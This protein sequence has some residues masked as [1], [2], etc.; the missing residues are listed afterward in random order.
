MNE[1]IEKLAKFSKSTVSGNLLLKQDSVCIVS[2]VGDWEE[3]F[4]TLSKRPEKFKEMFIAG[5]Y[6]PRQ[7]LENISDACKKVR[8]AVTF[9]KSLLSE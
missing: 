3:N 7:L 2:S 6:A 1:L 8:Y 4:L 5:S 9:D